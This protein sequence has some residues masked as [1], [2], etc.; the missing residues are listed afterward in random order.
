MPNL[1]RKIFTFNLA[2]IFSYG[3]LISIVKKSVMKESVGQ[4]KVA[5]NNGKIQK[6]TEDKTT[7]VDVVSECRA[8]S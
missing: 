8:I 3:Y 6:L 1:N 2:K 4:E 7:K 5:T